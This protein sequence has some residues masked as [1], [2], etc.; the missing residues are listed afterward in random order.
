MPEAAEL[1]EKVELRLGKLGPLRF[2]SHHDLL[3]VLER[4]FRRARLPVRFTAGFHPRPRIVLPVPLEVGVESADEP[5]EVEF[6]RWVPVPEVRT[7]LAGV[8]PPQLPLYAVRLLP[9]RRGSQ[10]PVEV[11]YEARPGEAGAEVSEQMLAAFMMEESIPWQRRRPDG[12][13]HL[14][15][16]KAVL[17]LELRGS[18]LVMRLRPGQGSA[19]PYEVLEYLLGSRQAALAVPVRRVKTTL[20]PLE[21]AGR[22]PPRRRHRR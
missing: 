10:P 13:V 15:L 14:D 4:A 6:S 2:L 16:R 18:T 19:R 5:V 12:V 21:V 20:A 22:K 1:K 8:L 9:P 3:R 17:S 7:R 11:V